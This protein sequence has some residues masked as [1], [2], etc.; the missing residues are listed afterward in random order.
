[1]PCTE[2][3][4]QPSRGTLAPLACCSTAVTVTGRSAGSRKLLLRLSSSSGACSSCVSGMQ[5]LPGASEAKRLQRSC[6]CSAECVQV[7]VTVSSPKVAL[8]KYR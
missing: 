4:V 8:S 6:S 5:Q 3:Q 2:L 1:M 7:M